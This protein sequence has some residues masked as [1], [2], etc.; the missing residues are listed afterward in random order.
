MPRAAWRGARLVDPFLGGGAVSLFAKSLGFYVLASDIAER[1]AL[2]G[3]ALVEN[4]TVRLRHP[5]ALDLFRLAS[6]DAARVA[7]RHV[8]SVFSSAQANWVDNALARA[9]A[10]ADPA[11][12][13]LL[14]LVLKLT[15]R[16]QP[17]SMLTGTDAR[18]AILGEFDAVSPRRLAHYMRAE[19]LLT[20]QGVWSIAQDINAGVFAGS[21]AARQCDARQALLDARADV[22][23]LDPPYAGTTSYAD[24]Y[25]V[26]DALLGDEI[27]AD[28]PTLDELL[29]AARDAAVVILSYG[30]PTVSLDDLSAL[31]VRHRPVRRAVAVP[32]PRL[33]S[34]ATEV[35]NAQSTEYIIVATRQ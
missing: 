13:L 34:L 15:L 16:L 2:I 7:A 32:Y 20:P 25:G 17:M 3:R 6:D 23:Y 27:T 35:T 1:S 33:R 22:A 4:S 30:G 31:V 11:R 9:Q 8:P 28:V 14:L 19:R 18:A 21:G 26:L 10:R 5:D 29:D 12:S 24:E